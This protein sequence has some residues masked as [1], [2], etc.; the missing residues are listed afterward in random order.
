MSNMYVGLASNLSAV[1]AAVTQSGDFPNR[2]KQ[3]AIDGLPIIVSGGIIRSSICAATARANNPWLR[4]ELRDRYL[5]SL[6]RAIIFGSS[7]ENVYVRVGDSLTNDGNDNAIC[8]SPPFGGTTDN[9]RRAIWRDVY[10]KPPVWGK[11]INFQRIVELS[12]LE[13]CEVAFYYG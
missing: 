4:V 8:G 7:G 10:C 5:V 13:I 6:V 12:F 2:G 11:Y 9:I 1:G 3:L